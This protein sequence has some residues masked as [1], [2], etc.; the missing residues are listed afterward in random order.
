MIQSK[1]NTNVNYKEKN[2]IHKKDDEMEAFLYSYPI[3]VFDCIICLGN[4]N[5]EYADKKIL[6][7]RIYSCVNESIDEQIGI[8]EFNKTLMKKN[9]K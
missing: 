4:I 5:Y 8:F 1:I 7:T 3:S 2:D 9:K 6:Y